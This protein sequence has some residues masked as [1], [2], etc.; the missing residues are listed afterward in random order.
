MRFT[1]DDN[2]RRQNL[3]KHGLD[4]EIVCELDWNRARLYDLQFHDDGER[5]IIV[6]PN[7]LNLLTAVILDK[8]DTKRVISLRAASPREQRWYFEETEW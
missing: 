4:F 1:W 5:E 8:G 7:K 6:I 2:K 3:R